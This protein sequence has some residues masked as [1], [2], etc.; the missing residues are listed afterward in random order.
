ML[1]SIIGNVERGVDDID[2]VSK[3]IPFSEDDTTDDCCVICQEAFAD[4]RS[5]EN[6]VRE[7]LCKHAF[8]HGCISKWLSSHTTCPICKVDLEEEQQNKVA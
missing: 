8:C 1:A 4:V 3:V 2:S 7:L 6:P 5:F